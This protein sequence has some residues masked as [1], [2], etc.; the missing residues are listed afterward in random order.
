VL[1]DVRE[2]PLSRRRGFSKTALAGAVEAAGIEYRHL[3]ALG[4]PKPVRDA[5]KGGDAGAG[6][7]GYRLHLAG[8][9][10][11][12]AALAERVAA[13]GV[14]LLCVE[15]DPAS[16]HRRLLADALREHLGELRVC[17]L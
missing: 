9:G 5:W 10:A 1:A 6:V 13:G 14:C 15:H 7:A 12:V 8:A 16:C 2:L 4:N 3:R 17:D 11:D